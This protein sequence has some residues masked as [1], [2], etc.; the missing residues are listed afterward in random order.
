GEEAAARLRELDATRIV[1]NLAAPGTLATLTALRAVGS[2]ARF[3]GCLAAPAADRVLALGMIEPA[4]RPIDPDA[5]LAL[6]GSYTTRGTRVV[7]AGADV[8]A[9]M[10]L[11]QA[12]SR[13]GMSVSMA[14]GAT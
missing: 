1:A 10:S 4:V 8:D 5:I 14:W 3:W 12:L 11:R 9:L 6:L 2:T 13:G 7:T